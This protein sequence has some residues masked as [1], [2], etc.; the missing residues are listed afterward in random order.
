MSSCATAIAEHYQSQGADV[1]PDEVFVSDGSKCDTG[2]IQEIF[3]LDNVVAITDPVYPVY[4]DTN[5]MAGRTGAADDVGA[6]CRPGLYA[7]DGGKRLR[8]GPARR[9][10]GPDLSVLAK[11]SDGRRAVPRL[12][13]KVGGLRPRNESHHPFRCRL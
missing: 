7:D 13:A 5:V 11:Q 9:P 12:A 8:P 10:C 3:S 1:A 6:L 4:V 2:N